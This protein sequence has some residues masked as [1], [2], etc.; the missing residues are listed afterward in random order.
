[1]KWLDTSI[2]RNFTNVHPFPPWIHGLPK[3]LPWILTNLYQILLH[4]TT[5]IPPP[6]RRTQ[7]GQ[8]WSSSSGSCNWCFSGC[9]QQRRPN[10]PVNSPWHE[11]VRNDEW[12]K[13]VEDLVLGSSPG[14]EDS[15]VKSSSERT[16]SVRAKSVCSY[17]LLCLRACSTLYQRRPFS[18]STRI[19]LQI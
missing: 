11:T 9:H 17:A 1:M 5:S 6:H 18:S 12:R 7:C 15:G 14:V 4:N 2:E 3:A 13:N 8:P 16:L 19:V 10:I